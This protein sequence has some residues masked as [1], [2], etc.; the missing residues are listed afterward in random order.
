MPQEPSGYQECPKC[1][2]SM[3]YL[4]DSAVLNRDSGYS[5]SY[6]WGWWDPDDNII[7]SFLF[8]NLLRFFSP[9]FSRLRG[10]R[11]NR[12]FQKILDEFPRSVI[13]THCEYVIKRK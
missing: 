13:C 9:L 11:E 5:T 6:Y 8:G 10:N 12:K 2:F 7:T 3:E 1:R 4:R